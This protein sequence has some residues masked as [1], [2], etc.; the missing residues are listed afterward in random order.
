MNG[1]EGDERLTRV[2]WTGT[3]ASREFGRLGLWVRRLGRLLD[4]WVGSKN[5]VG[6]TRSWS[7]PGIGNR[8]LGIHSEA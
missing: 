7:E 2:C 6:E 4:F 3:G 8:A 5:L 1:D